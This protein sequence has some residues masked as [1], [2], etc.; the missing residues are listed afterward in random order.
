[1]AR[2]HTIKRYKNFDDVTKEDIKEHN[3]N[4]SKITDHLYRILIPTR[5]FWTKFYALF[6]CDNSKQTRTRASCI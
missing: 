2:N 4:W 6:Y 3:I 1:M 5:K